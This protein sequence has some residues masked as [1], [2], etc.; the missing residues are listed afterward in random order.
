MI[1]IISKDNDILGT[2]KYRDDDAT[3]PLAYRQTM[4]LSVSPNASGTNH[5]VSLKTVVPVVNTIDGVTV[6]NDSFLAVTKFSALQHITNDTER[7]AAYDKHVAFLSNAEVREA[8]LNGQLT[9]EPVTI[10]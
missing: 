9:D 7:A 2:D 4:E 6:S 1:K 10:S 8:F 3:I 5:N